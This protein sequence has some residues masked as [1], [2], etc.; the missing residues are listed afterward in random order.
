[1]GDAG[2][3]GLTEGLKLGRIKSETMFDDALARLAAS[4]HVA[5]GSVSLFESVDAV[6]AAVGRSGLEL[7]LRSDDPA[8]DAR[9]ESF[10]WRSD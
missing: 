6:A 8:I 3:F 9:S 2:L 7:K 10:S 1:M 5:G 4:A